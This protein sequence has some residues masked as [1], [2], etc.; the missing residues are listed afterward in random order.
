MVLAGKSES[1]DDAQAIMPRVGDFRHRV[2]AGRQSAKILLAE[3][4]AA[5]RMMAFREADHRSE[6]KFRLSPFSGT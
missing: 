2:K 1:S 4:L 6:H 5:A 3:D